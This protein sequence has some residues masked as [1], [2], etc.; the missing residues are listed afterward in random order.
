MLLETAIFAGFMI[1]QHEI[2]TT[3][4]WQHPMETP[5][6][7]KL[8]NT[9]SGNTKIEVAMEPSGTYGDMLRDQVLNIDV[10]VFRV[11]PKRAHDAAEVYD[12]VPSQHD[13]KCAAIIAK[14]HLDGA[15]EPWPFKSDFER[16]LKATT[17]T[18]TLYQE[19]Y[20]D[21]TNR[22]EAELGV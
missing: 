19:L 2:H 18:M 20:R 3:V 8:L 7:V 10:P 9:L 1:E 5:L 14:L 4:K 13:P 6:F 15:S 21:N 11:S 22:L 16:K 12:G 17:R